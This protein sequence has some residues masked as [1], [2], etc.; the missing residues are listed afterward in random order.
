MKAEEHQLGTML[1][2]LQERAKELNCLYQVGELLNHSGRSLEDIFRSIIQVLPPGWQYPADCQARII[3][4][5]TAIQA[6][7]FLPTPW[8]Q[9]ASIVVQQEAVGA[10]E[11]SYRRELPRSD[12]GPFLKEER[13]LIDTIADRI[14][15][16]VTQRRLKAAFEGWG[17]ASATASAAAEWRVVLEF[18]RDTDPA[19]LKRISRK[20]INHLSWSGVEEAKELL[21]KASASPKLDPTL[22]SDENRPLPQSLLGSAGD[23]TA[24]VFRIAAQH[25]SESEI[26]NSVTRWIKEDKASFLVRA[27]EN[28][29]TSLG[30]VMECLERYRHIGVEE[31]ELS[32]YTQ[33]GLRVSLI[34]RFFS[35]SL[36]FINVAKKFIDVQDFYDLLDRIVFPPGCHG[37]L[38]GKSAGLFLAKKII[39]KAPDASDLLRAVRVPKTWYITSDWIQNFVH[40]N[41]LEDVLNRKYMEIEQVRQE[42]PHLVA[43]FKTSSF[44]SEFAKGLALA[45]DDLGDVPLIVRSSSLLEDRPGSAFSGKY[46][47]LFLGNRG[48]KEERL[49]ALMDAVAEV[50]ASIFG[51]DPTEYRAERGLLDVHEEMGIMIQEVV[52]QAVGKYFLPACSGVAFSNNEFRWSARIKREDGLIRLVPG[53][54]TRAVDRVA[55]DYPVLIAPGQPNLRVNVTPDEVLRY[56]PKRVDLINLEKNK[57]ETVDLATLL[58]EAGASYPQI[59]DLVSILSRDRIEPLIG[60]LPDFASQGVAFTFE[61]LIRHTP[62]VTRIRELLQLLQR[63]LGTPVDIEFAYDGKDFYLLQCRPQS[64]GGDGVP[65]PI[66]QNLPPDKLIFSAR[67]FVS[68]GKVP[69]ITH[70]VY[71]DLE[72]Y[73]QLS[74][75][76]AMLDIGRA[77][78]KLNKLLPKRQFM[79]VGPGRWGSRG[80]IKLGVPV[81]Y[82]DINN[83]AMLIEVARQKGNYLPELSFGTHFFQDLVEASIRYLPLYPDDPSTTFNDLFLRRSRNLLPEL[84]PEFAHLQETLRV[85]DV[86]LQTG[87]LKLRVLMNADL[88]QAVGF[89]SP[90]QQDI[91]SFAAES[92]TTDRAPNEH[93]RWRFRMAQKI[94]AELD[95]QQFGVN[96]FYLFGSTKNATAGP[97]SDI[98]LLLHF[99]GNAQ[100]KGELL[101]WLEG[102]SQC[103]AEINFLRTGYRSDG[104]LDVHLITDA[105]IE[106]RSSF[107]VKVNAVTDPARKLPMKNDR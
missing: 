105:D 63:R 20:L 9:R 23:L 6:P 10:I 70:I 104:L 77:V 43:L 4:E 33:T 103:L 97:A 37:K 39:D 74:D 47:S 62:F 84:L 11:V 50:Y 92:V 64:Y 42:Y 25:M 48:T 30:E 65:A 28:Q 14:A 89:L 91:D 82:S 95:G 72:G 12:E 7:E 5:G 56:S 88:Q 1:H 86:P 19:L 60:P 90:A 101:L 55:D 68:N 73:S 21:R 15:N 54:G 45:L 100:Q 76:N 31:G 2:A 18:L 61:G 98:D 24:E 81:T 57:F 83:S 75:Q 34:R 38:G 49:A 79:L 27:L 8:V 17:A 32:L 102:W 87:G 94:A 40:H 22:V 13:R 36:T 96:A 46:K 69:V 41:D 44:P 78:G 85:I 52:G 26:L 106:E 71:V 58:R 107:A 29:D 66:P 53:L 51:P 3:F 16:A 67:H 99:Q 59:R 35:E 93:W 80:D